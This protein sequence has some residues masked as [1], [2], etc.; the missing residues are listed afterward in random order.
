MRWLS[1]GAGRAVR[2]VDN[3]FT[4]GGAGDTLL[5]WVRRPPRRGGGGAGAPGAIRSVGPN[6]D[7]PR[8]AGFRHCNR[9]LDN[10]IAVLTLRQAVRGGGCEFV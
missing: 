9:R 7:S 6:R 4:P 10:R 2:E 3:S 1:G 8:D 5:P